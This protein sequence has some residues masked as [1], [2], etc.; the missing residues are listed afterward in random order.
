M[1]SINIYDIAKESWYTQRTSGQIPRDRFAF[2]TSVAVASDNSSYNIIIHGG[3]GM[4]NIEAFSDTYM[5]SL[6]SFEFFKLDKGEGTSPRAEHTCHLR[7]NKLFIVGGHGIDQKNPKSGGILRSPRA[8][9]YSR[10]QYS[11][12]GLDLWP[13]RRQ[14]LSSP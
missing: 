11:P 4:N 10:Y 6:P 3:V 12:V 8:P 1:D 13:R 9:Q 7:K 5:L 14:R 2:C